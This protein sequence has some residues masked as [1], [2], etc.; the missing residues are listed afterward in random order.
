[1]KTISSVT[2]TRYLLLLCALLSALLLCYGWDKPINDPHSFRQSQT[3]I[4]AYYL[5]GNP[6]TF[7]GYTTPIFGLPEAIP[8]EAPFYQY[9]MARTH[10]WFSLPLDLAGR[11][12]SIAMF[13]LLVLIAGPL[14][15]EAGLAGEAGDLIR[16]LL[17]S[18]PLYV[19][20]SRAVMIESTALFLAALGIYGV[21]RGVNQ[22]SP[23]W[24][25][26]G[27]AAGSLASLAKVTTWAVAFGCCLLVLLVGEVGRLLQRSGE[28]RT[29]TGFW[30]GLGLLA[31]LAPIMPAKVWIAWSDQIKALN[32][33]GSQLTSQNLAPWNFGGMDQRLSADLYVGQL[34]LVR[35]YLL[36]WE[37][38]PPVLLL[39]AL[40]LRA[41]G[42]AGRAWLLPAAFSAAFLSGPVVFANL[43]YIHSYYWYANGIWLLFAL[44]GAASLLSEGKRLWRLEARYL[45]LALVGTV[46]ILG[47]ASWWRNLRPLIRDHE[48]AGTVNRP[49]WGQVLDWRAMIQA[50][51]APGERLLVF[52]G[53][54]SPF[55]TYYAERKGLSY[56]SY[57]KPRVSQ[58]ET[59]WLSILSDPKRTGR[60]AAMFVEHHEWKSRSAE[61]WAE[62]ARRQGFDPAP[63]PSP[64]GQV[65]FRKR[66]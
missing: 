30:L 32:E 15:R 36:G 4:S 64:F 45:A 10:E 57:H 25:L 27:A 39:L 19:F 13:L 63:E 2:P 18:S 21:L 50:R 58:S 56:P 7:A 41:T 31:A 29:R 3:A 14:A 43:Y 24:L 52:S 34:G 33:F 16:I 23:W 59:E 8:F 51:V 65:F 5:V 9:L 1:M 66:D 11:I 35:R 42:V 48:V 46:A 60:I 17:L 53:G 26:A 6:T 47:Y 20:W 54:Y 40:A 49:S 28:A 62:I 44:G 61:E 38:L 22:R 12:V 37:M 55:W